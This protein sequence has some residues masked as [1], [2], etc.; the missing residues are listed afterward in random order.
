MVKAEKI[1]KGFMKFAVFSRW[2]SG[3][4]LTIYNGKLLH[5]INIFFTTSKIKNVVYIFC[6]SAEENVDDNVKNQIYLSVCSC[7][8][9]ET[10]KTLW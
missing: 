8:E 5:L 1:S 7:K 3:K 6:M 10:I 2:F 9:K 4:Y